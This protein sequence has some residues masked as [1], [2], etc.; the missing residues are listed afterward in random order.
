MILG[1]GTLTGTTVTG[2]KKRENENTTDLKAMVTNV[3]KNTSNTLEKKKKAERVTKSF[4]KNISGATKLKKGTNISISSGNHISIN[5]ASHGGGSIRHDIIPTKSAVMKSQYTYEFGVNTLGGMAEGRIVTDDSINM[6]H[7]T[8]YPTKDNWENGNVAGNHAKGSVAC[9]TSPSGSVHNSSMGT[10]DTTEES[11]V[12]YDQLTA[13]EYKRLR[14]PSS[15]DQDRAIYKIGNKSAWDDPLKKQEMLNENKSI[16]Q[17][18]YGFPYYH[19]P[20]F[21]TR[22]AKYDYQIIPGDKRSSKTVSMEDKLKEARA[23]FGI[24]VHGSNDIARAVKFNLYNKIG[25]A[26]V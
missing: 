3:T 10:I 23:V 2:L 14:M 16:I 15:V 24:H 12:T 21:D 4:T 9:D 17:N 1:L 5:S 25:R 22:A 20:S 11:L 19:M 18:E 7:G 26:H 8:W 6:K 13:E